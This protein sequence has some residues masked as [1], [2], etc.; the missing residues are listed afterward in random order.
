[1]TSKIAELLARTRSY[2]TDEL[3]PFWIE[4]SPDPEHGGFL[5]YFDGRGQPTGETEKTF[6]MQIRMVFTMASAHRAGYGGGRCAELAISGAEFIL[7]HF[8]DDHYGGWFWIADRSGKPTDT[9]KVGYGQCFAMYAFAEYFLAT[10]DERGLAAMGRT[11][12]V[13]MDRMADPEHGGYFEILG[14]DWHRRGPASERKSFDVHMHMMEALTGVCE[15]GAPNARE[16]LREV[17]ALILNRML[18]PVHGT[19]IQQFALDFT[20]LPIAGFDV[21]WGR[22]EVSDV[23]D[24]TELVS[25]GHDIEFAWLLLGAADAL[26][27]PR[28]THAEV[29]ARIC[30]HVL[31]H[32]VDHDL[33]GVYIE[34]PRGQSASNR[35][36]QFW[37]QAEL[38]VVMLEAHQLLGE[39]R[40]WQAFV[41]SHEFV[42]E[43]FVQHDAGGEWTALVDRDGTA[44]WDY[45][46]DAWKISYHTVRSMIQVV[47][48]LEAAA[49]V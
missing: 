48:L 30:D 47:R 36:K 29:V 31:A 19:G 35:H 14:R 38:L 34:G 2:L 3:L 6:L 11:Y 1:M 32:G 13:V 39:D 49:G 37:Q 28:S 10:G 16:R 33:G 27:Q 23:E 41:R 12:E 18:D 46:G 9:T 25:Y 40:Y 5:T 21:Q 26:D 43:H 22:D 15:A 45:L 17:V 44:L 4:R 8:W 42:F 24:T 20:P 7:D